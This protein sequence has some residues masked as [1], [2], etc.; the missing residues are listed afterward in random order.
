MDIEKI[1]RKLLIKYEPFGVI[2]ANTK[3]IEDDSFLSN[4]IPTWG[5]NGKD[6][7]Y[8][9]DATKNMSIE[10]QVFACAHEIIHIAF[11]H[12]KRGIGKNME[13]W[14][15]A[16]DAI[17]NE[18]LEKDGFKIN[19]KENIY[20]KGASNYTV[21]ELYEKLIEEKNKRQSENNNLN[22]VYKDMAAKTHTMWDNA[23]KEIE[24][25]N[26]GIDNNSKLSKDYDNNTKSNNKDRKSFF[27]KIFN[28]Q[29]K[30]KE[31]SNIDSEKANKDIEKQQQITKLTE[32]GEKNFFNQ[33]KIDR[34]KRLE[35]LRNEISK[36]IIEAGTGSN[37]NIININNIGS[38]QSLVDW[39]RLLIDL[40]KY[41]MDWSYKNASIEDG[42]V[43]PHLEEMPWSETEILFDTS[44]SVSE[45]LLRNSLRE[46]KN[47][48]Q[49]S[50]IKAGC[51]DTEF[52]G[53]T[54]IRTENDIDNMQFIGRGGTDFNA[55][56]NAFSKTAENK[57]IF[58]DGYASMS[59]IYMNIIWIVFG[60]NKIE[61]KGGKVIYISNEQLNDLM[62]KQ[63]TEYNI[64]I[65]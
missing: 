17:T 29:D 50:K 25:N 56:I 3:F 23:M 65:K 41:D 35:E 47:I 38:A 20:I 43:T 53:F 46:C 11:D 26:S 19:K 21:E 4:G 51:F 49:F 60:N 7:Y 62:E 39:R 18:Y 52:Y 64:K 28:R 42:V 16:A 55:A 14:N 40:A 44:G 48:L 59:D 54:E 15:I 6:I 22:N 27:D 34:K 33:N 45:T 8:H 36:E 58:T 2:I 31:K 12:I 1:K 61:P 5:T 57:I 32:L 13:I 10:E 30:N 24:Q 9:P 63:S 37:A